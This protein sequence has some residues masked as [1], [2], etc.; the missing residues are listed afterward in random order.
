MP[1][2]YWLGTAIVL[3]GMAP[4]AAAQDRQLDQSFRIWFAYYGDHPFGDSRLGLHLEGHIR[5]QDGIGQ[6]QQILV[7]PGVN[8]QVNRLLTLTAGYTYVRAYPNSALSI[9]GPPTNEHRLWERAWLRYHTGKVAWSSRVRFENRF[10]ESSGVYRFELK[11]AFARGNSLL[12]RSESPRTSPDT[13]RYGFTSCPTSPPPPS[14]RTAPTLRWVSP[15][16]P[17]GGLKPDT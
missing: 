15:S 10:V 11:T 3:L 5:R 8:Y 17:A 1:I 4:T 13:T 6:W 9:A 12:F 7:R 14:T 16:D 2:G